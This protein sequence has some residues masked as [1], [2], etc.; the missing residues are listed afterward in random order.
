MHSASWLNTGFVTR[1]PHVEQ[2][3]FAPSLTC[4][5]GVRAHVVKL[6]MS[7]RFWLRIVMTFTISALKWCSIR[8]ICFVGYMFYSCYLYLFPYIGF[9]HDVH[10]KWCSLSGTFLGGCVCQQ[11]VGIPMGTNCA[12]LPDDL[13]IN[14][15]EAAFIHGLLKKNKRT[16]ALSF[17]SLKYRINWEIYTVYIGAAW[18]LLHI[19]GKLTMRTLKSSLFS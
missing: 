6:Y 15:I 4:L 8:P 11:R 1:V 18:M 14:S 7:S 3:L 5:S 19:Y 2:E 13:F 12:I 16:L 17:N 10:I 9:R